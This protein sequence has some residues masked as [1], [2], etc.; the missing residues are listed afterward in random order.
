M[1]KL[2]VQLCGFLVLFLSVN[3][4]SKTPVNYLPI[5]D[6]IF[7]KCEDTFETPKFIARQKKS[8]QRKD[9]QRLQQQKRQLQQQKLQL[10][11]LQQQKRKLQ[12]KPKLTYPSGNKIA[13]II[14][15]QA[16]RST[17]PL[18]NPVND[19]TAIAHRLKQL[20]FKVTLL[21]NINKNTFTQELY[22]FGRTA[23]K[24]RI[25][26]V[27]YAGHALQIDGKNYLLPT[28]APNMTKDSH[29]YELIN[30][31]NDM[32]N[33]IS[34]AKVGIV[35]LDACRNNPLSKNVPR[36]I[37]GR[38]VSVSRGLARV[39]PN[40]GNTLVAYA[41]KPGEIARDGKNNH[42]PFTQAILANMSK[43]VDI[44]RL[45]GMIRTSVLK[46]TNNQQNPE[47]TVSLDGPKII[48]S[49]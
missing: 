9:W 36:S 25:A 31:K 29:I 21:K 46:L 37:K 11:K 7:E 28:D 3:A 19:A 44:R 12:Q 43:S 5:C 45:F 24:A 34:Q 42:S 1:K 47:I 17:A 16:Y 32:M 40:V 2:C 18:K 14:G 33:Q 39:T 23:T 27:F 20:G 41:T 4:F 30:V 35:I 38:T 8:Q 22:N 49:R 15:N 13:L 6:P 26:L 10:Q 48:L